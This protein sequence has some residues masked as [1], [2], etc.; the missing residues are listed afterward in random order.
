MATSK[1]K[2]VTKKTISKTTDRIE[3]ETEKD[4]ESI[5]LDWINKHRHGF[6]FKVNTVG[7]YDPTKKVYRN[8]GKFTLK[9]TADI[10]GIFKEKPLAI[11]VK[12]HSGKLSV[13]QKAFLK[14]WQAMGGIAF[15]T[16]S[17]DEVKRYL[18]YFDRHGVRIMS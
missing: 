14:K 11:E 18:E 2:T 17:L 5:I 4:I 10:L 15:V 1:K 8:P 16:Y 6:A 13:E 12:K 9:G 3:P 7:I